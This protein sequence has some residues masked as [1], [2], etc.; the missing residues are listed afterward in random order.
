[1]SLSKAGAWMTGSGIRWRPDLAD[2]ALCAYAHVE[3]ATLPR[4]VYPPYPEISRSRRALAV[5]VEAG[6][7]QDPPDTR[8]SETY[9]YR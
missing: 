3:C 7:A 2:S 5:W 6:C 8:L 9:R 1:M 4:Y